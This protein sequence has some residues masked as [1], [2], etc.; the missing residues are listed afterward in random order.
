ME[1]G[2]LY[3]MVLCINVTCVCTSVYRL[4]YGVWLLQELSQ[5]VSSDITL[6]IMYDVACNLIRHLKTIGDGGHLLDR[7]KFALPSFHAYGHNAPC[8][9]CPLTVVSGRVTDIVLS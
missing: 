9:V 5:Q 8:Q 7:I 2:K 3:I 6:Y 1:R 4:S